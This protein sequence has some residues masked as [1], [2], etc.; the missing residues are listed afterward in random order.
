MFATLFN[1]ATK[2]DQ[3]LWRITGSPLIRPTSLL[4][5][6]FPLPSGRRLGEDLALIHPVERGSELVASAGAEDVAAGLF[7]KPELSWTG[8]ERDEVDLHAAFALAEDLAR[9]LVGRPAVGVVSVGDDKQVLA[10]DARA[11]EIGPGGAHRVA[12][13]GAATRAREGSQRGA[14]RCAIVGQNRPQRP[15]AARK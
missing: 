13:G 3:N 7:Q 15:D 4:P 10:E 14:Q 1:C 2:A 8:V 6:G 9:D 11:I 5:G 12:D